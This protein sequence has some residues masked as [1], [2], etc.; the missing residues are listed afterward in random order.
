MTCVKDYLSKTWKMT[1]R[2]YVQKRHTSKLYFFPTFKFNNIGWSK[3][4][5]LSLVKGHFFFQHFKNAISLSPGFTL[6]C[7]EMMSLPSPSHPPRFNLLS[8]SLVSS[9]CPMTCVGVWFSLYSSRVGF[10]ELLESVAW[11][12]SSALGKSWP[13]LPQVL[14]F[15]SIFSLLLGFQLHT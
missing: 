15:C 9:S 3:V 8:L 1:R 13:G 4:K 12:L 7:L 5:A 10:S 11:F 14:F 2:L 6:A